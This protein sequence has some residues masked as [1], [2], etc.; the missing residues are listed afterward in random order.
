MLDF[1]T[2][3]QFLK[4][5][6]VLVGPLVFFVAPTEEIEHMV[7]GAQ[8]AVAVEPLPSQQDEAAIT[9]LPRAA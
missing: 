6:A 8:E 9:D 2:D 4:A 7:L 3:Q 5:L 1:L